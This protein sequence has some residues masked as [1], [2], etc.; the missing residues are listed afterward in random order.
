MNRPEPTALLGSSPAF[1]DALADVSQP[2]FRGRDTAGMTG[3]HASKAIR[4]GNY[5]AREL[6][7]AAGFA[8]LSD[9]GAHRQQMLGRLGHE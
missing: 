3:L 8:L 4:V 1:L 9:D 7:R 2:A 6:S 5:C